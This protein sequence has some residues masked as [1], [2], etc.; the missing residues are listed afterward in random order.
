MAKKIKHSMR[1]KM[2]LVFALITT[3]TVLAI[4]I[5]NVALLEKYY[6]YD[7]QQALISAYENI[8]KLIEQYEEGT[9][10]MDECEVRL[11]QICAPTNISM[12]ILGSDWGALYASVDDTEKL[13]K[14]LMLDTIGAVD[15]N[16]RIIT[17]TD[18]YKLQRTYDKSMD[19]EYLEIFG[20]L[21]D[22]NSVL[23]RL[24]IQSIKE[25]VK[26]SNRFIITIGVLALI[27]N[28]AS[29]YI[30]AKKISKPIS[31]LSNIAVEMSKMNFTKKYTGDDN[32][33]I[34]LLGN[35][36]NMLSTKLEKN[37]SDLK[38]ANLQLQKDIENKEKIDQMR[39]NF[40]DNVS[41]E[42]KT[43]I[44]LI[45]GYAEGV[46]ENVFDDAESMEYYC[47]VII[48]EANKMNSMVKKLLTLNQIESSSEPIT[49]EHFNLTTLIKSIVAA[50]E[51]RIENNE[52]QIELDLIDG[53][54]CWADEFMIE[55]V[56]TNYLSNAI[57][58]CKYEK[59]IQIRMTNENDIIRVSIFNT[60]DS[61]PQEDIEHIWEKFYKVDK[62]RTREYGG[63]GIGLSIVKAIMDAH[64]K[65]YGVENADNGVEFWFELDST[66]E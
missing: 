42:L 57:N 24:P 41:H 9:I 22:N 47:D 10:D 55:E 62:A 23:M 31:D 40:L 64:N 34:G 44:A 29:T 35:T 7:K 66:K 19:A 33:E 14:R 61:I 26:I 39:R 38:S 25:N 46:K 45:Q 3:F 30:F 52:I 53:T 18:D 59:R 27:F 4:C 60:G 43:P 5:L 56:I 49:I 58:H 48:D 28:I 1:F 63:N 37:I 65:C 20:Y 32:G 17:K 12:V 2:T 54:Y 13:K 15:E 16:A 21:E 51:L 11:E 8:N 6:L 36:M 50:N